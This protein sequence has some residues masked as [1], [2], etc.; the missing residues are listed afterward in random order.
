MNSITCVKSWLGRKYSKFWGI[1]HALVWRLQPWFRL[2]IPRKPRRNQDIFLYIH[3]KIS[4]SSGNEFIVLISV[5]FSKIIYHRLKLPHTGTQQIPEHSSVGIYS[6]EGLLTRPGL[7]CLQSSSLDSWE[8]YQD[9]IETANHSDIATDRP[10]PKRNA[11]CVTVPSSYQELITRRLRCRQVP[12]GRRASLHTNTRGHAKLRKILHFQRHGLGML[13]EKPKH[14]PAWGP[15][16]GQRT[17]ESQ[18]TGAAQ[19]QTHLVC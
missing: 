9:C 13:E 18:F 17:R 15:W 5:H 11:W 1:W 19:Q 4:P 3:R 6:A 7:A 14:C 8:S 2:S 16:P 12:G 10:K